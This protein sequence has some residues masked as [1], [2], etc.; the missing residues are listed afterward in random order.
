MAKYIHKFDTTSQHNTA[1]NDWGGQHIE[2]WVALDTQSGNVTYN[3]PNYVEIPN[4]YVFKAKGYVKIGTANNNLQHAVI[5]GSIYGGRNFISDYNE[6]NTYYFMPDGSNVVYELGKTYY[7]HELDYYV[8]ND[9]PDGTY[10]GVYL[11]RK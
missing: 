7:M 5:D 4:G 6:N 10:N 1:Y 2:P 3:D 9:L 11:K 8:I